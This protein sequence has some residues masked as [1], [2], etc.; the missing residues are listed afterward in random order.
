MESWSARTKDE[1]CPIPIRGLKL[2]FFTCVCKTMRIGLQ[3]INACTRCMQRGEH[4]IQR[5]LTEKNQCKHRSE[6]ATARQQFGD[7]G[8]E[9]RKAI[10]KPKY[11]D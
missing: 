2:P 8:I 6:D 9:N 1:F 3:G 11:T 5:S 10:R 4:K 7:V